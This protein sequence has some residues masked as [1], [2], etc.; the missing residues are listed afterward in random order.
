M[1][2]GTTLGCNFGPDACSTHRG[3][4]G[5]WRRCANRCNPCVQ[6]LRRH[7]VFAAWSCQAE[8]SCNSA[9]E[10]L[11]LLPCLVRSF[12]QAE[13][14]EEQDS[15]RM[16]LDDFQHLCRD[17]VANPSGSDKCHIC[18]WF[19]RA[20]MAGQG[21]GSVR[22]TSLAVLCNLERGFPRL[23]IPIWVLHPQGRL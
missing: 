14:S 5:D 1:L 11:R 12:A 15:P 17:A 7:V 20:V 23:C 19:C 4:P 6:P 18:G 22:D 16:L 9:F 2:P 8:S 13:E 3:E 21:S 10:A